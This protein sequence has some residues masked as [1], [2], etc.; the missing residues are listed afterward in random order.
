MKRIAVIMAGGAGE[1][2]WPLSR[3]NYPKQLLKIAGDK[4]MLGNVIDRISCFVKNEDILI[5][6]GENLKSAIESEFPFLPADNIIAEP[7]P[8][9]TSACLALACAYINAKYKED[10]LMLVLTAD[11][12]I[13]DEKAFISDC[14]SGFT[15]A[16]KKNTLI[17]FGVKP[18]RPETGYGYIECG[19]AIDDYK[20]CYQ[21]ASFREKPNM[22]TAI[23]YLHN[24]K[25]LWN[26]GQFI[27]RSKVL[28][29]AFIEVF[30][31][32]GKQIVPMTKALVDEKPQALADAFELIPKRSID[33]GVLER[34]RNVTVVAASFPW[35]DIGSW[36][37][38]DRIS[39]PDN[40]RNV[41]VGKVIP[42]DCEGC[43]LYA[44]KGKTREPDYS[45]LVVAYG[46]K[47]LVVV[48]TEDVMLVFP[49]ELSQLIKDVVMEVR[50]SGN[51][52]YL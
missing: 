28:E 32:C 38:L 29:N 1:R 31:E 43:T 49:K 9:N 18:T 30:P 3:R 27:W 6:T 35:D 33:Y 47:D 25:Y 45:K 19:A 40:N 42:I 7:C 26:S 46:L 8:R 50:S 15:L 37:C 36:D 23:E 41:K 2:F 44:V 48:N 20:N 10:V 14:E 52:D 13:S 11:S 4:S 39:P 17:L 34:Y 24:G 16:E 21:V 51:D 12:F 22:E 5:V